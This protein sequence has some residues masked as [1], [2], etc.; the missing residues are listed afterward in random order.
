[1]SKRYEAVVDDDT[2]QLFREAMSHTLRFD[3]YKETLRLIGMETPSVVKFRK[4]DDEV[5]LEASARS[6]DEFHIVVESETLDVDRLVLDVVEETVLRMVSVLARSMNESERENLVG[7]L[8]E[9][10]HSI[11]PGAE[12]ATEE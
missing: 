2:Y 7:D 8:R 10:L 1:V 3:G 6:A 4:A 11:P 9:L 5:T 12:S